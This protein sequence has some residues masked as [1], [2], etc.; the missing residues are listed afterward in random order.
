MF[1]FSATIF[2]SAFLL[3][4]VQPVIAKRILPWF[5][6]S[7]A[8]WTTCLLFFQVA[9]LLG[10]L[11]AHC[12]IR[13][14]KPVWQAAVHIGLVALVLPMLPLAPDPR[15]RLPAGQDPAFRIL[16]LLLASV[17]LPY[18]L[19]AS[20]GPLL[21]AWY[22]RRYPR[23]SPYR[24]YS[25]SN[26][27]SMLAL[28]GY[29]VLMEPNL[30]MPTQLVAW[31]AGFVLFA[32]LCAATAWRSAAAREETRAEPAP[33]GTIPIRLRL[34]W[35][36]LAACS[37]ALLLAITNYLCQDVASF[38][39]LWTLPLALYLLSFV[40]C[41]ERQGW[42]RPAV[43]GPM[44]AVLLSL[45]VYSITDNDTFGLRSA[46]PLMTTG[47][48]VCCMFCHG[49]LA[50]RKPGAGGLTTF[51]LM[52]ALGS[53]LGALFVALAAPH[54]FPAFYELPL[55]MAACAVLAAALATGARKRRIGWVV[56]AVAFSGY[57]AFVV[58][59]MA[60]GSVLVERNFYGTLRVT[61]ADDESRY[62]PERRLLHASITHGLQLLTAEYR[63]MPTSYYG[64]KTGAGLA[65][66]NCRRPGMRVGVIGLGAGTLAA[67]GRAGDCYRF[68]E[69]NPLV[70][71][72]AASEF[73]FLRDTPAR[74][75]LA[76]GDARLL[77]EQEPDRQFDVL[78]VDAFSGDSIPVH[79]LTRE[80]FELYYRHMQPHGVLAVHV[81]N[82]YLDL[83]PVVQELA[84][85]SG[86]HAVAI[87]TDD[88]DGEVYE[89]SW[90]LVS[91]NRAFFDIPAI[92]TAGRT[93]GKRPGLS[94]WTDDS[95]SLFRIVKWWE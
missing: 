36:A 66:L 1:R 52:I 39:F 79:L 25:L 21:Q 6:G 12:S 4:L 10:Y 72:L 27:G 43:I 9:L 2:T 53:V 57:A 44:L 23:R 78:V 32:A 81:S 37:S 33:A 17:G 18:F 74:V 56:Y 69:I 45:M 40:L 5:G 80:A 16:G 15:W 89:A 29:P 65:L 58:H 30:R 75:E 91:A 13:Y 85:A 11:Y 64:T 14:L 61:E 22:A 86:R 93:V 95:N 77:L 46:I 42:Y 41:F 55:A 51:Y 3:F 19:L 83:E 20:T 34:L 92:R 50:A 62:G 48:F 60:S 63:R 7:A 24:L 84:D 68:Y 26:L 76:L 67:Y 73:S 31:S 47:L 94:L 87:A 88:D 35:A 28:L 54:L 59:G 90:V 82:R 71:R 49:E 8:V 38:P 70:V